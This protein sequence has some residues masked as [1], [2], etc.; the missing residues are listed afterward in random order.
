MNEWTNKHILSDS[1]HLGTLK[2]P[3][4][5]VQKIKAHTLELHLMG[6]NS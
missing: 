5:E 3:Q 1:V 4:R 2:I 6:F